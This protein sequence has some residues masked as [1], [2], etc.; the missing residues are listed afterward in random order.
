M[1][2]R[3]VFAISV[4][5]LLGASPVS[6]APLEGG[7]YSWTDSGTECG[8]Y[9]RE[10][11]G[12]GVYMIK[13]ATPQTGGQFFY[14][15]DNYWWRD[16]LTNPATGSWAIV[17]G[18]GIFKEVRA[19]PQTDTIVTYH[20]IEAGQPF[21]IEDMSGNVVLR[22][23]GAIDVS[24]MFDT[25]GDSAPGGFYLEDPVVVRVAGPHPGFSETFDFCGFLA[26]LI[27]AP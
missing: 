1:R 24:Y 5:T 12:G 9:V 13:D 25:L 7:H 26:G 21:V 19:V 17:R 20:T 27:G 4:I 2:K 11:S 3:L 8:G 14:F 16:V 15:Q 22:D 6:A 10:S 23:R 18:N